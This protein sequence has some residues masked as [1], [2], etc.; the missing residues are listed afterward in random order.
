[1]DNNIFGVIKRHLN[2]VIGFDHCS[3]QVKEFGFTDFE[4][5]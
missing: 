2:K 3:K 1:M 4:V 5:F